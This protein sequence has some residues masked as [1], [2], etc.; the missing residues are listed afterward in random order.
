MMD[1]MGR[2]NGVSLAWSWALLPIV[3]VAIGLVVALR[4]HKEQDETMLWMFPGNVMPG[5]RSAK[6]SLKG[7]KSTSN[8]ALRLD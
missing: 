3:L 7:S 2:W 4:W 1:G 5:A 8:S 6:K